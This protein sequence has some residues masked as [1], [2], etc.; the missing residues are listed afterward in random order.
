MKV[1][2]SKKILTIELRKFKRKLVIDFNSVLKENV[3][4]QYK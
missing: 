4:I 3:K 2:E 1:D